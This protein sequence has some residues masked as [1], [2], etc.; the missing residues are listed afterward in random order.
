MFIAGQLSSHVRTRMMIYH[1]DSFV[2]VILSELGIAAAVALTLPLQRHRVCICRIWWDMCWLLM[3]LH[4]NCTPKTL[5]LTV[6]CEDQ[7]LFVT[8]VTLCYAGVL[9]S[10]LINFSICWRIIV[11]QYH[12][13]ALVGFI[14]TYL[15]LP[16]ILLSHLKLQNCINSM[17]RAYYWASLPVWLWEYLLQND[18]INKLQLHHVQ[19]NPWMWMLLSGSHVTCYHVTGFS[20]VPTL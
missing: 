7:L 18:N 2:S 3:W 16:E 13:N 6:M 14:N 12:S 17:R 8:V 19:P 20:E 11:N 9:I 5:F 10:R 4:S 1:T 15:P